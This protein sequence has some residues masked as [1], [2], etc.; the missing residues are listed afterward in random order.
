[1]VRETI[2]LADLVKE[3]AHNFQV[4]YPARKVETDFQDEAFIRGDRMMLQLAVN[5]LLDNAIKYSGK[6]SIVLLKVYNKKNL[7]KLQVIDEGPGIMRTDK[8]KIFDKY[9][10]GP[11]RQTKGTGLGLYL[12]KKIVEEHNGSISVKDNEPNGSTFEMS[13]S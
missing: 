1:M 5:N 3:C 11:N 12:T 8:L 4:R 2:D 13:F 7:I 9:F 6:E 10:R